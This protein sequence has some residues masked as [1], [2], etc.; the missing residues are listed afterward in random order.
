MMNGSLLLCIHIPSDVLGLLR[1]QLPVKAGFIPRS[2][3]LEPYNL[4]VF[5]K[6]YVLF[7]G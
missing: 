7:W 1:A 4:M 5:F 6:A 3:S 2:V